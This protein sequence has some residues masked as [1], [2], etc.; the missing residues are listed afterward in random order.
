VAAK[1]QVTVDWDA[2]KVDAPEFAKTFLKRP[3]GSPVILFDNQAEV[4]RGIRR[5]TTAV[6][7]RQWGKSTGMAADCSWFS[8]THSHRLVWIMAPTLDQARIIFNEV[9]DFF[10]QGPLKSLVVGKIKNV[11]FPSIELKNGTKIQAR[12]LNSP[13]YIR[14]NRAHR[15]YID[16]AAFVKEG[17]IR[18]TVEPMFTVTGKEP[19][20]ALILISSPFG[21]G[22]FYDF[23]DNCG[24]RMEAGNGRYAR[25]KR[26]SF[27]NPYADMV[28]LEEVKARY[29]ED[30]PIWQAEYLG[31]FQDDE[32]AV[33]KAADIKWAYENWNEDWRF[34]LG[35][36]QGHRY[37]QGVDL[38]NMSDFF[39]STLLDVSDRDRNVLVRMDRANRR[40]YAYYKGV[41]RGNYRS[42]G[43]ARTIVDAT[44]LGESVVEDL[45]DINAIPYKFGSNEAK[46]EVVQ[47]LARMFQEHRIIIPNLAQP[48]AR[49]I[50]SELTYFRYQY[51]PG[52]S[53]LKMEAPRGKHDDIFMSLSLGAHLAAV[54]VMLGTFGSVSLTPGYSRMSR[55]EAR[56]RAMDYNPLADDEGD[57]A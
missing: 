41:A 33:L 24:K 26:T 3:D 51:K 39:V 52:S 45:R 5:V 21:Q 43:L 40:G 19:D 6:T 46:W 48:Q 7:G 17:A 18:E 37:V 54:P 23:W 38:A 14:G 13:Q 28:Y 15:V 42:Y 56:R 35:Y 16:E 20:S 34:P 55:E 47:E 50:I 9:A 25:F 1:V 27:D 44:S 36:I 8:T 10:R 30:S 32:L 11:P 4:L 49:D 53:V 57:V 29:G 22:E 2:C 31:N 12:G